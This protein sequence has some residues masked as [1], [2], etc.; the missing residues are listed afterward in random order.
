VR[1]L[2]AEPTVLYPPKRRVTVEIP[3]RI[4]VQNERF[5]LAKPQQGQRVFTGRAGKG[6]GRAGPDLMP[7]RVGKLTRE[8]LQQ[9]R[10]NEQK[11][12]DG[13]C[14]GIFS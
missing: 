13:K 10:P 6:K 4:S 11:L 3:G 14:D 2:A 12:G 5:D 8:A 9:S 1:Y 7:S